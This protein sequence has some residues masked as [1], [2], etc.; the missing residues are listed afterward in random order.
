MIVI[1]FMFGIF[2][3][4]PEHTVEPDNPLITEVA[5]LSADI[6]MQSG[7]SSDSQATEEVSGTATEDSNEASAEEL[8]EEESAEE[9]L[10]EET[11]EEET[12]EKESEE[13]SEELSPD[14][15]EPGDKTEETEGEINDNSSEEDES[16]ETPSDNGENTE[17]NPGTGDEPGEEEHGLITN[18]SSRII[19]FSEL[20]NDTLG[21]YA[22]YSDR[23]IDS[24]LKVNYKHKGDSG[25]G[26]WL[27]GTNDNY[28]AKLKL[29]T[30]YITI[31]YTDETGERN[32]TRF[33]I[34]YQANK[35]DASTPVQGSHP[36]IIHTNLDDW[37]GDIETNHF[38]F[39]V[40]A[41]TWQNERIYADCIEVRLNGKLV[42]NPTGSEIFEYDLYFTKPVS[43]DYSDYTVTVLA[44]DKEGNSRFVS[45]DIR[46]LAKGKGEAIDPVTVTIDATTVNCGIVESVMVE[47][48]GGDT[49][50]DA[51]LKMF[52]L[53]GYTADFKGSVDSSFYLMSISKAYAFRG[54]GIENR[55]R[56]LLERDGI[57][58]KPAGTQDQLGEFHYTEGSGWMYF[59]NGS[60]CPGVGMNEWPLQGGEN[61]TLRFTLAYGKDIGASSGGHGNLSSYCAKWIGGAVIE[62][63]HDYYESDRME[64]SASEDGYIEYTCRKCLNIKEEILPATGES[65]I[66]VECEHDYHESSRVDPTASEDGY[67]EYTCS[68]CLETK[69]ETLPA[70]GEPEI[71]TEC[72]H[73][74]HESSRVDPTATEDG[75]VEYTC[76]K[77]QE[78]KRETLPS[79]G[80]PEVPPVVPEQP[81]EPEPP[82]VEPEQPAEPEKDE[83]EGSTD[84]TE[85]STDITEE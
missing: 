68:K 48:K 70:T 53:N 43:G 52:E 60:L 84:E 62:S 66:P 22:Y 13:V 31:Y 25:N 39:T 75:Y 54:A 3:A 72:I 36:P 59:I 40:D 73:D 15:T 10:E 14:E 65:E 27:N 77:C 82:P 6:S 41:R 44:W 46:Y 8:P 17:D 76:S 38:K 12:P 24:D 2:H 42:T 57:A 30:N 79:T 23:T 80:E 69:R 85:N 78:T 45:Y 32:W 1:L 47:V 16:G 29:G 61:I 49:A 50:A 74:Y 5:S 35:A 11:I 34:N 51:V 56:E 58:M 71:P 37:T 64:P 4:L 21:F 18:L 83:T 20:E 19:L 55:L 9:T 81:T 63:E 33:A 28:T 67:V 26:T 7:A